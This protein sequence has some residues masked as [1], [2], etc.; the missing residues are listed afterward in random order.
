MAEETIF[1][2]M[3][4]A[5][6]PEAQALTASFG[7]PHRKEDWALMQALGWG[8]VAERQGKL[9]GTALCWRYGA[10]WATV[11]MIGVYAELQGRGIG[12]RLLQTLM[13]ELESRNLALYAT[14]AGMPLYAA[15]GF[16]RPGDHRAASRYFLAARASAAA[17]G[18][19]PASDGSCGPAGYRHA[20]P[21][22]VQHGPHPLAGQ[23]S[24]PVRAA[25]R[26]RMAG[27]SRGSHCSAA[28]DAA[29]SS[30]P[31]LRLI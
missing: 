10:D 9:V 8:V 17:S 15:I 5:D 6:V 4:A 26:W 24:G 29:T 23:I 19:A 7:W 1:A 14:E 12:R 16:T 25:S 13:Q 22:G 27:R 11:G 3:T 18:H 30:A 2:P 28:S 21:N 31:S 20:G